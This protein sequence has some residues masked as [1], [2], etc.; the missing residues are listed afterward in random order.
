M[1]ILYEYSDVSVSAA[2]TFS[3]GVSGW[4]EMSV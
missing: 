2:G 1:S 3:D 4:E